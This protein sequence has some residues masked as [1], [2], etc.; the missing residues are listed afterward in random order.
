[1]ALAEIRKKASE[2]SGTACLAILNDNDE[3][4]GFS[5]M[6]NADQL[7]SLGTLTPDHVIRTKPFAWVIKKDIEESAENFKMKY[8]QYF[9]KK[10]MI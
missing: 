7:S 4:V 9:E 1:M 10:I 2:I 5:K 6:N 3:A 8:T